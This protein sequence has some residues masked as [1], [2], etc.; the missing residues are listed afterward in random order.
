[1]NDNELKEKLNFVVCR[2][3]EQTA[4]MFPEPADLKDGFSFDEHN[5]VMAELEFSGANNGQIK[6]LVPYDFCVELS[7]NMLGEDTE[8]EDAREKHLDALKEALN[9]IAGQ[10]MTEIYGEEDVYNLGTPRVKELNKD[11]FLKVID[12]YDFALALSDEWPVITIFN[13]E[14]RPHE[15]S[16]AG[17]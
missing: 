10:L 13:P 7:A 15:H 16:R 8:D 2:V 17:S 11:E 14:K 6:F 5:F 4:F 3:L 12:E 9:V 1:M